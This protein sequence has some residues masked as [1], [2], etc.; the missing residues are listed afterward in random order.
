MM[1]FNILGTVGD[2]AS[3]NRKYQELCFKEGL[4]D[5]F[6]K[7]HSYSTDAPFIAINPSTCVMVGG[8][9]NKALSIVSEVAR[10]ARKYTEGSRMYLHFAAKLGRHRAVLG[11]GGE[12]NVR[13]MP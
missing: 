2:G 1:G 12:A 7:K 11:A 13:A 4:I 8:N 5:V 10:A 6:L 3:E 9:A